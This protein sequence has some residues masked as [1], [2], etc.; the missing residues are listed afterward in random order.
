MLGWGKEKPLFAGKRRKTP[1][2]RWV[3]RLEAAWTQ[4][5]CVYD[6]LDDMICDRQ[7]GLIDATRAPRIAPAS[8]GFFPGSWA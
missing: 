6:T 5:I 3:V 8:K 7:D 1:A 4:G 2:N